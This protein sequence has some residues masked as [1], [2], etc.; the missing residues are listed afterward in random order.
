VGSSALAQ[1]I[2]NIT[3]TVQLKKEVGLE[4]DIGVQVVLTEDTALTLNKTVECLKDI[5]VDNVQIKPCHIHPGSSHKEPMN[6]GMYDHVQVEMKDYESDGFKVVVRT[7]SMNR[8]EASRSYDRCNGFDFYA[9]IA[10]NGDVVPCN[11]FYRN[12][13]FIFGNINKESIRSIWTS[14]NRLDIIS[15]IEGSCFSHC[16]DYRCR[17]DVMNR[18]LHRIKNPERCDVFI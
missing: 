4:C 11:V 9:L 3:T 7:R 16:G 14:T 12:E 2:A 13:G 18:Y 15:S 1:V 5:G 17:L 10:A 6:V 8:L